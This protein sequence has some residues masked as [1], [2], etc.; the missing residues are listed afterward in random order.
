MLCVHTNVPK[1]ELLNRTQ[2]YQT[3]CSYSPHITGVNK[4]GR[5][6]IKQ[7]KL[8]NVAKDY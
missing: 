4:K 6:H 2:K 8:K 3:T 1:S 5:W 7:N